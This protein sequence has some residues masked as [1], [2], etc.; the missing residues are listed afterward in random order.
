MLIQWTDMGESPW[1]MRKSYAIWHEDYD[2]I[3]D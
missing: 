3:T 2:R 1:S